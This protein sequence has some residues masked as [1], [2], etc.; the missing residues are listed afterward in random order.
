MQPTPH[1]L[2]ELRNIPREPSAR[3]EVTALRTWRWWLPA[4]LWTL[5]WCG[6]AHSERPSPLPVPQ[7]HA[8]AVTLNGGFFVEGTETAQP[9]SHHGGAAISFGH[10]AGLASGAAF[11]RL[12][13]YVGLGLPGRLELNLGGSLFG[14]VGDGRISGAV[15]PFEATPPQLGVSPGDLRV[16][17][18]WAVV[19]VAQKGWGVLLGAHLWGP[20]GA[21]QR[22]AGEGDFSALPFGAFALE[23]FGM[24]LLL[25]TGVHLRPQQ[26][27]HWGHGGRFVQHRDWV[28]KAALRLPRAESVAWSVEAQGAV[29]LLR[30][31]AGMRAADGRPVWLGGG[32]DFPIATRDRLGVVAG[33]G[34]SGAAVPAFLIQLRWF[35]AESRSAWQHDLFD[36]SDMPQTAGGDFADFDDWKAA[37]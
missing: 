28:W 23:V 7:L 18:L 22:L 20:T 14:L 21:N 17:L 34:L 36:F 9:F 15:F 31:P 19:D 13:G 2:P 4:M 27:V 35:R 26:G 6:A 3:R 10:G 8:P 30:T 1:K 32:V 16:S 24:R 37:P 11:F 12:D 25:N 29:A 33:A 5:L